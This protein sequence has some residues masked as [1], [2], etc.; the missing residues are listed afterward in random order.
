MAHP[1]TLIPYL[2]AKDAAAAIEFYRKA[3]GATQGW[4]LDEPNGR[5]SHADMQIGDAQ[6]MIAGEHPEFGFLSPQTIGG[7]PFTL[8]LNVENV[9]AVFEQA[10]QAGAKVLRPVKDQFYGER[11]GHVLDPFGFRWCISTTIEQLTPEDLDARAGV[12][13]E[14]TA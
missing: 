13:R 12:K 6:F 1:Q 10:V 8:H 2:C 4:R 3:F 11:N 9:D 5:V 7:T 14:V